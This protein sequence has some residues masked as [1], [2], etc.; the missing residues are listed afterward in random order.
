MNKIPNIVI[1]GDS[2]TEF[3]YY[4][5]IDKNNIKN[6][7][8]QI[9]SLDDMRPVHINYV[10]WFIHELYQ[11]HDDNFRIFNVAKGSSG[12]HVIKTYYKK[13]IE[14]LTKYEVND[15]LYATIQLSGLYRPRNSIYGFYLCN[16]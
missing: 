15:S 14:Y 11:Y 9:D 7:V 6:F 2:F 12:N 8:E 13:I 4:Q 1:A 3:P 10:M 5:Y 16:H